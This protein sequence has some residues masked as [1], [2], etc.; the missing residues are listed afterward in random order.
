[1]VR[2]FRSVNYERAGDDRLIVDFG[3]DAQGITFAARTFAVIFCQVPYVQSMPF[4]RNNSMFRG[5][6]KQ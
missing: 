1:M 2:P 6:N 5:E 3:S 4:Q